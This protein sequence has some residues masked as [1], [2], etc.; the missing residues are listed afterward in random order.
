[1]IHLAD[2]LPDGFPS[3]GGTAMRVDEYTAAPAHTSVA[4]IET[5]LSFVL[6]KGSVK[7]SDFLEVSAPKTVPPPVPVT[8]KVKDVTTEP[9]D[10]FFRQIEFDTVTLETAPPDSFAEGKLH[11]RRLDSTAGTDRSGD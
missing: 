10:G 7:Q 1:M 5:S 8:G 4:S 2:Q 11:V 6:P 3:G 9:Y